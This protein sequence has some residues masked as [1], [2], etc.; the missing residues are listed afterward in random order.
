MYFDQHFPCGVRISFIPV[1]SLKLT[2]LFSADEA[3][4]EGE[5]AALAAREGAEAPQSKSARAFR[6]VDFVDDGIGILAV[7]EVDGFNLDGP[8]IT[9]AGELLFQGEVEAVIIGEAGGV[10]GPMRCRSSTTDLRQLR[11]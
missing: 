2:C 10:V 9:A 4:A 8:M 6:G 5:G 11:F 1:H 3:D 7:E